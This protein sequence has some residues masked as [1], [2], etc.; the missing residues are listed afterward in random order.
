MQTVKML[1]EEMLMWL[2]RCSC[3]LYKHMYKY[4]LEKLT[5]RSNQEDFD[6]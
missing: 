6:F 1:R 3:M 5:G 2:Y 4:E